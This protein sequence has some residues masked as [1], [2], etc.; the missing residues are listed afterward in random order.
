MLWYVVKRVLL[1]AATVLV[2]ATVTFFAMHAIPGGPFDTDKATDPA[3]K[4]ALESRFHLDKSVPE[5]YVLY[6]R[7]ALRGDLGVSLKTG[8]DISEVIGESFGISA[9][10]GGTSIALALLFGL[11]LGCLAA[12]RHGRAADRLVCLL[13]TLFVAV[14]SFILATL[15]LLVFCLHLGW[16]GVWS[17]SEK[18]YVLPVISLMLYP[19]AYIARLTRASMLDALGR[20]YIRTAR[21]KGAR[22]CAVVA[23]H[24]L[25][26]AMV[27]VISYIGPM[28]AYTLTGSM[29]VESVFTIGG[30]GGKFVESIGNR[31]YPM[32]MATTIVLAALMAAMT[33]VCDLLY[34]A[35]DPRI[36]LG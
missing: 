36:E 17:A 3:A 25:K 12:A 35:V 24:A 7:G 22:E 16:F 34:R 19:M 29:V 18:S 10:L 33:L 6:L 8:R 30:L 27:P 23:R 5:Q 32:I 9:R 4:A 26:N 28:T 11:A 20:D 21:A 14:P 1:A 31:D 13:T 2:V 15:L